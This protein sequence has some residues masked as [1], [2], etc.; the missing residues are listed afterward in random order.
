MANVDTVVRGNAR[1]R[2]GLAV[3]AAHRIEVAAAA[4][5]PRFTLALPIAVTGGLGAVFVRSAIGIGGAIANDTRTR[6]SDIDAVRGCHARIAVCLAITAANRC[7]DRNAD[8]GLRDTFAP[9]VAITLPFGAIEAVG[10]VAV[11]R[12]IPGIARTVVPD[13]DAMCGSVADIRVRVV[14]AAAHRCEDSDADV[15]A[16]CA[17]PAAIAIADFLGAVLVRCAIAIVSTVAAGDARALVGHIDAV[18]CRFAGIAVG[19]AV[20]T[21][22]RCEDQRT[23]P[24]PRRALTFAV[25]VARGLGAVF[26]PPAIRIIPTSRWL[27]HPAVGNVDAVP[28]RFAGIGVSGAVATADRCKYFQTDV[29]PRPADPAPSTVAFG[30]GAV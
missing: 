13:V 23:D 21:A 8:L 7:E 15:R 25:A 28:R 6:V 10:T 17:G 29:R 26:V 19:F 22:D 2:I 27:T 9:A 3:A 14:V 5:G 16:R 12:T 11:L 24:R 18:L 4:L 30:L 20:A 1:V